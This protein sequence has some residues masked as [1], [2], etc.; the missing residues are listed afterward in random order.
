MKKILTI[1]ILI[2]SAI[3]PASCSCKK[4]I[5]DISISITKTEFVL[6][7]NDTLDLN[8]YV[9]IDGCDDGFECEVLDETILS[10]EN[11][12]VTP[13]SGGNTDVKCKV[14]GYGDFFVTAKF[15]VCGVYLAEDAEPTLEKVIIN[16]GAGKVATNK[17][18]VNEKVTEIPTISCDTAVATYNY[19][20]GEVRAVAVG[21][22]TVRVAFERCE[23]SFDVV[24]ENNVFVEQLDLYN[25]TMYVGDEGKFEYTIIPSNANQLSFYTNSTILEVDTYGGYEA[26]GVGSA[27]VYCDYYLSSNTSKKLTKSFVVTIK[28]IPDYLNFWIMGTN[29][30]AL[31]Y[32]FDSDTAKIVFDGE[33][34]ESL[35]NFTFSDNIEVLSSGIQSGMDGS[36]FVLFKAKN[37]GMLEVTVSCVV[38]FDNTAKMVSKTKSISVYSFDQIEVVAKYNIYPFDA[39]QNGNYMVTFDSIVNSLSFSFRMNDSEL[40]GVKVYALNGDTKIELTNNEFEIEERG[41]TTLVAEYGGKEIKRFKVVVV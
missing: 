10:I 24:V 37:V 28:D 39:D 23:T 3:F 31:Q 29:G 27:T 25:A 22:T 18:V 12:V 5:P 36:K 8:N 14:K 16:L 33:H 1:F 9:V 20:T 2:L 21:E 17:I 41:E 7:L 4:D 6:A 13:K 30:E 32:M 35:E 11:G 19:E 34:Y 40:S 38:R 26:K 15:V